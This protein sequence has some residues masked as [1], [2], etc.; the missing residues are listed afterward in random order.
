MSEYVV[1]DSNVRSRGLKTFLSDCSG[2]SG[3]VALI[4]DALCFEMFKSI[5][6][7]RIWLQVLS[8][9]PDCFA[10]SRAPGLIQK[11]ELNRCDLLTL[12]DL[13]V[14]AYSARPR[15]GFCLFKLHAFEKIIVR[16]VVLE[17]V[18]RSSEALITDERCP[19]S[20]PMHTT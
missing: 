12:E 15:L 4:P 13:Y 8:E 1:V 20:G 2:S 16:L 10:M 5:G 17:H 11:D 14:R 18:F 9:N 3:R 6:S 19:P 7:A